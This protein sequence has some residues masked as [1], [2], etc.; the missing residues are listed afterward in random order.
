ML[1]GVMRAGS[2]KC[3]WLN[4]IYGCSVENTEQPSF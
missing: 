3:Y 4:N 2:E 1:T